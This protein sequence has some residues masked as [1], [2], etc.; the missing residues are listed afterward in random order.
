MKRRCEHVL[1]WGAGGHGKVVA[2]LVRACGHSVAGFV[3]AE[4]AKLN[5]VAES[6]VVPVF[7]LEEEF[8]L[9][10]AKKDQL[11]GDATVVIP[12][13]GNNAVR[14]RNAGI[15]SGRTAPPLIHPGSTASP[16]LA[17]GPGTVVLAGAVINAAAHIGQ[18]VIINS[19]AVVEHDCQVADGAH[20]SPGAVLAGGVVIGHR[21]WIGAGAVVIEG[22]RI[23]DDVTVAA[24]AVVIRDVPAGETVVGIPARPIPRGEKA[25]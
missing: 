6:G 13:M 10:L 17:I 12:A 25:H 20:I 11:P 18:A 5:R 19:G 23:G 21:S 7:A 14:L 8:I 4:P 15:T 24:G 16:S 2:D 22:V 9:A 3:D 1:I